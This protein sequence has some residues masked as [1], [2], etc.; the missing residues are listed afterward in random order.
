MADSR[1]EH[2]GQKHIP[3]TFRDPNTGFSHT[4]A[5]V[6]AVAY[7][8]NNRWLAIARRDGHL[9][10]FCRLEHVK[11]T[12]MKLS[13]EIACVAFRPRPKDS[14]RKVDLLLVG[15]CSG[16]VYIYQICVKETSRARV[17]DCQLLET[18]SNAHKEQI[19]YD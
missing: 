3:G 2:S 13:G 16:V 19:T 1:S 8:P 9:Q 17:T 18:I 6:T 14:A 5:D 4:R 12:E 10:V 15:G 7:A 11:S